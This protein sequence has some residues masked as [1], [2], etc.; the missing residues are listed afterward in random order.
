MGDLRLILRTVA[1]LEVTITHLLTILRPVEI[2]S[3][4][5]RCLQ[6]RAYIRAALYHRAFNSACG[7]YRNDIGK[8]RRILKSAQAELCFIKTVIILRGGEAYKLVL[9]R[10]CLYDRAAGLTAPSA[11]ADDLGYERKRPLARAIVAAIKALIGGN[12][13]DERHIFKV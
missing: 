3:R 2:V 4:A 7:R 11:A 5:D 12:D 13:T 6:H 1:S 10:K 9:R 8:R